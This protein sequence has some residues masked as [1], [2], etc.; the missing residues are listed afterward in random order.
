MSD[1]NI[2]GV[3]PY[4]RIPTVDLAEWLENAKAERAEML[5]TIGRLQGELDQ[6]DQ[7]LEIDRNQWRAPERP[8]VRRDILER[9]KVRSGELTQVDVMLGMDEETESL[10]MMERGR[11]IGAGVRQV[12]VD[13][14]LKRS[15]GRETDHLG[16]AN[17][18]VQPAGWEPTGG[19]LVEAS[20]DGERFFEAT[21]LGKVVAVPGN[22]A[23]PLVMPCKT[24]DG[25]LY[26]VKCIRKRPSQVDILNMPKLDVTGGIDSVKF[27][28]KIRGGR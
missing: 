17:E 21:Y 4:G 28:R 12:V 22:K 25:C 11:R 24:Q 9:L 15:E 10:G 16:D 1:T 6:V 27:V 8:A 14:I 23:Q 7:L 18:M 13:N 19:T 5:R 3:N 20:F 2:S 26:P